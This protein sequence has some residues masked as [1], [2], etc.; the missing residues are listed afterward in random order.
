LK[1]GIRPPWFEHPRASG[2]CR[3]VI[4]VARCGN[5]A[6]MQTSGR[7]ELLNK[8]FGLKDPPTLIAA[9][10]GDRPIT[11]SHLRMDSPG[12]ALASIPAEAAYSIHVHLRES[13]LFAIRADGSRGRKES[14]KAGS[15]C[16]FDLRSP[17]QIFFDSPFQTI[18]SHVPLA[19]LQEFAQE[20][21]SRRHVV[22]RP[23]SCGVDD[24]IIAHLL[25]CLYPALE[26]AEDKNAHF[27]DHV[28]LALQ[29]HL[30]QRYAT[31]VVPS[32]RRGLAPWQERRAKEA[33]Y[34]SLDKDIS[35]AQLASECGLSSSHFARAFK[36]ATGRPP[37]RWLLE[38]RVETAQGLL[39]NSQMSL[40]EIA[41]ACG[42]ADQSHLTR[43][44]K[45]IAGTS[46]GAWRRVRR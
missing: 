3:I 24:P 10:S 40:L 22:L 37:Y 26:H 29:A 17:P 1:P 31:I 9:V 36:Q 45:R 6:D 32:I 38:R 43:A 4:P 44:F 16:F 41:K 14:P 8:R 5:Q 42:F 35:I 30:L 46:P 39:L 13:T 18:R 12:Q 27:V 20:A 19:A 11:F 2:I 7:G 33:M 23:P 15:L 34:A 25:A 28:A 21:G